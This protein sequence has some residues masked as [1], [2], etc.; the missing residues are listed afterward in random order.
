MTFLLDGQFQGSSSGR[1]V[2]LLSFT[3]LFFSLPGASRAVFGNMRGEG[4][5]T[6]A[7]G[8]GLC[9][10]IIRSCGQLEGRVYYSHLCI[11][12][13]WHVKTMATQETAPGSQSEES[14]ALDLASINDIKDYALQRPHQEADSE[15][16]SSVETLSLPCSSDVDSAQGPLDTPG[17]T[18]NFLVSPHWDIN[19]RIARTQISA[20]QIPVRDSAL[21]PRQGLWKVARLS[22]SNF[23]SA[24]YTDGYPKHVVPS[25]LPPTPVT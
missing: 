20:I 1:Q 8:R 7:C 18:V 23:T 17:R 19:S 11:P 21:S 24:I 12:R 6:D 25:A 14:S 5:D 3:D 4:G 15:A 16:L 2:I 13:A 9:I 10:W 22:S